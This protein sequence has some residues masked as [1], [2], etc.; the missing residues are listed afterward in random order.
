MFP[1]ITVGYISVN[2]SN[3]I[4]TRGEKTTE[5]KQSFDSL[6]RKERFDTF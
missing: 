1:V 5:E 2:G 4:S 3:R 6:K